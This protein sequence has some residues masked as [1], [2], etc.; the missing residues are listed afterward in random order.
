MIWT[1]YQA[2][3]GIILALMTVLTISILFAA[4]VAGWFASNK[5]DDERPEGL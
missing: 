1:A 2:T 3:I 5:Y 4:L